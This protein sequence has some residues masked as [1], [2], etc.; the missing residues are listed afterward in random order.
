MMIKVFLQVDVSTQRKQ[1]NERG[2]VLEQADSCDSD[3]KFE[4]KFNLCW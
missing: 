2:N 1:E 3:G 4:D